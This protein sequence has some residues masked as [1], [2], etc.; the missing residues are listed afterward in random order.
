MSEIPNENE[1]VHNLND[2]ID[3]NE[4]DYDI[5]NATSSMQKRKRSEDT[6]ENRGAQNRFVEIQ[7]QKKKQVKP[8]T[9]SLGK[10]Q[11]CGKLYISQITLLCN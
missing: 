6:S 4:N 9:E 2:D 7:L 5:L 10:N 11:L 1:N 8:H 3:S